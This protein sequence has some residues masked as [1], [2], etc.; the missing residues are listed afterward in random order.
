MYI[1]STTFWI[2]V[3]ILAAAIAVVYFVLNARCNEKFS[4]L[5]KSIADVAGAAKGVTEEVIGINEDLA[6]V[7]REIKKPRK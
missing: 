5:S 4:E 7:Q 3:G 2:V 6:A 1:D